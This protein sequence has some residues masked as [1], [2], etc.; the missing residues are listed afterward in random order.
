MHISDCHAHGQRDRPGHDE[1]R[2]SPAGD[3]HA[4]QHAGYDNREGD[5]ANQRLIEHSLQQHQRQI[6]VHRGAEDRHRCGTGNETANAARERR[7]N[8]L[9]D[10][11]PRYGRRADFP[12]CIGIARP[13][14]NRQHDGKRVADDR[15]YVIP[16]NVG[17]D[18]LAVPRA[19]RA[20]P[21]CGPCQATRSGTP[22]H[23]PAIDG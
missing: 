6:A 8:Q 5:E 11:R 10:S 4:G 18:V 15:G 2:D 17:G 22:A 21:P 23:S 9:D 14:V 1:W 20:S 12:R 7:R 19:G 16:V 3:G 13:Q